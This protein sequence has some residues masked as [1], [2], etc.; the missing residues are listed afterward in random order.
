MSHDAGHARLARGRPGRRRR[1]GRAGAL[2]P[3]HRRLGRAAARA[4][5]ALPPGALDPVRRRARRERRPA[6]DPVPG[7][8]GHRHRHPADPRVR[9]PRPA[10][11]RGR[12][13]RS[14]A[15]VVQ[16]IA[17]N[18]FLVRSGAIGQDVLF[19]LRRRVFRHFQKLSPAFHD[20]YTS[21][22][23]ISRQTSDVDAIYEM[24]ETGF[25]GLVTAALTLVGTAVLL[26]YLDVELGLVALACGPFLFWL[27]N[28]FRKSSRG[29][30]PRHP[31]EGRARHRPLRGVD[32]RHPRGP[33]V[34][35][36][37]PQPGDPR[38]RQ[39]P[40]PPRPTW[41][42]SGW[43]PGSCPASASSATSRSPSSCSTAPTSPTTAT[44]RSA[45]WR[46]SC[47]TC[48]SSSSR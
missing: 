41:W 39:R 47:S 20:D 24:L 18:V 17:R 2:G 10:R 11:H 25:D 26:L 36:R 35:P 14:L 37:A 5:A 13:R 12:S 38:R 29:Q 46:R 48:A 21:G 15:T 8:G 4:A 19:E 27:T 3:V 16:A 43:S 34:P 44:S 42:R 6:L 32:G 23:V 9:R 22:R 31:R 33:G 7:Q 40:V 1:G 28:W 45:C 30:L